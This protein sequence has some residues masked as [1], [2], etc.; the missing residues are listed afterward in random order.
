M[1]SRISNQLKNSLKK[2]DI[3]M[4]LIKNNETSTISLVVEGKESN[5]GKI[6]FSFGAN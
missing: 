3:R 4:A 5:S 2:V 6:I 1:Y